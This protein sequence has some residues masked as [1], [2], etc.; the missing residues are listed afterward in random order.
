MDILKKIKAIINPYVDQGIVSF[1]AVIATKD[2]K[3][4]FRYSYG[5][6]DI[7]NKVPY[8]DK[9]ILRAFSCT[10][11]FTAIAVFKCIELGLFKLDDPISKYF[12]SFKNPVVSINGEKSP[13]KR[14]IIIKDLLDMRAGLTY[15]EFDSDTG[16]Y[17]IGTD[18]KLAKNELSTIEFV[19]QLGPT[20]LLFSPGENYHYS[21]CADV[22]GGLVAKTSGMS[23]RDFFKKYIFD[24]IGLKNTDFFVKEE[25]RNRIAKGYITRNGKLEAINHHSLGINTTG[26]NNPFE[27]GGAGLFMTLDDLSRYA[28][29]LLNKTEGILTEDTFKI[30]VEPEY[31]LNPTK[32]DNGYT[33]Y[34]LMRHM[35]RP[36]ECAQECT[37]NEFGW[38]GMIGTFIIIDTTN[39]ITFVAGFQSFDEIKW[40]IVH[41]LKDELFKYLKG[42]KSA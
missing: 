33:Y 42:K 9:T 36:N 37:M 23:L 3:E 34:N 24:Q 22:L 19:E 15:P 21:Y 14:E 5:Y 1:G 16:K 4:V 20:P 25:H 12:P 11:T 18:A 26:E 38:D 7:D 40:K 6:Q 32:I 29:C 41:Q 27:S 30:L 31:S 28:I 13:A 10:K 2:G 35:L 39:N 17:A 8:S